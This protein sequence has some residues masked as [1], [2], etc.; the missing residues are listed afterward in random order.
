[1]ALKTFKPTTKSLRNTVLVDKRHLGKNK[2][3][4]TL[5]R[6]K[7]AISARNNMG[8]RTMRH[9]GGGVKRTFRE[10]DFKRDKINIPAKVASIEYDPNRTANIALLNYADGEKRYILAPKGM[11]V[12][13][14]VTTGEEVPVKPGNTTMLKNIP[15]GMMVHNIELTKGKGGQL[16]RSAGSAAQIQGDDGTGYMQL[17]MPSGEIR[18]VHGQNYGTIGQV[19]NDEYSNVKL[20]KAGRKRHMGIRPGVRGMAMHAGDHPHGGGE[21]KGQVGM[22]GGKRGPEDI[23]GNRVGRKTR[24]N[25][26]TNKYIIKRRMNKRNDAVKKLN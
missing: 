22:S 6:G 8:R 25:K 20:G 24:R 23:Y 4:K 14:T 13:D 26:S 12:G 21:G 5:T 3:L 10:I 17:K 9:R 15:V 2:P 19:G 1:M 16:I 7:K 18:L 11:E